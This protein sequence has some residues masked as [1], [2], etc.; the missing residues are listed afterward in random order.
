MPSLPPSKLRL[1]SRKSNLR[2]GRESPRPVLPIGEFPR[3]LVVVQGGHGPSGKIARARAMAG[4]NRA[5]GLFEADE[6]AALLLGVGGLRF[7]SSLARTRVAPVLDQDAPEDEPRL[8]A[9]ATPEEAPPLGQ[10]ALGPVRGEPL[11]QVARILLIC[12][13]L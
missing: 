5:L 9:S 4:Q 8:L 10:P 13:S 12:A 1:G 11:Y 3:S 2:S 6:S 7:P